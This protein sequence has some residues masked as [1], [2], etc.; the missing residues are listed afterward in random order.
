VLSL[1]AVA[2]SLLQTAGAVGAA[3]VP[4]GVVFPV[5]GSGTSTALSGPANSVALTSAAGVAATPDAGFLIAGDTRVLRVTPDGRIALVAGTGR[6]GFSGD[7]GAASAARLN[8]AVDTAVLPDGSILIAESFN[9]VIRSVSPDG[10]IRTV[11]GTG[12]RGFAGDDGPAT[13][14][15]LQAPVGVAAQPDGGFLIVDNPNQRIRRVSPDGTISTV[16]GSGPAPDSGPGAFAGDGGP[17]TAARLGSP[18]D[19]AAL[20][21]GG[22][23]IADNQNQVIRRVDPQG[24]IRTVAGRPEPASRPLGGAKTVGGLIGL[25]QEVA[26]TADGGFLIASGYLSG[27]AARIRWMSPAGRLQVIAGLG[28]PRAF[29]GD[30]VPARAMHLPSVPGVAV[31]ADGRVLVSGDGRVRLLSPIVG[32][33]LAVALGPGTRISAASN[34]IGYVAT[35]AAVVRIKVAGRTQR[36]IGRAGRNT[37]RVRAK[38]VPGRR[39]EVRLS[40]TTADG[41]VQTDRASIVA[42]RRLTSAAAKRLAEG[43]VDAQDYGGDLT[44]RGYVGRCKRFGEARVDCQYWEHWDD[45]DSNEETPARPPGEFCPSTLAFTVSGDGQTYRR[46]YRR[47]RFQAKPRWSDRRPIPT[48]PD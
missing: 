6:E 46:S 9:D 31:T 36:H 14:A 32:P 15:E 39:Y 13:A 4:G 35:I 40:A 23:L 41:Q 5:A 47:C 27:Q 44:V 3:P 28:P 30:G 24:L 19:V 29:G 1:T 20:P 11:A 25:P 17:A 42:G 26:P 48:E 37:L 43:Y 22:F 12:V 18:T 38:L 10:R 33:R 34:A 21:D 16:A 2:A 7:G 8:G 45:P